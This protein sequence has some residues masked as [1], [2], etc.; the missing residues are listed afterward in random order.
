MDW[1]TLLR[2]AGRL[3]HIMVTCSMRTAEFIPENAHPENGYCNGYKTLRNSRKVIHLSS[4]C[5]E[6]TY[7]RKRR[8]SFI[9]FEGL[10]LGGA[11]L[12][13]CNQEQIM[14]G[15]SC[16]VLPWASRRTQ[17]LKRGNC[18]HAGLKACCTKS[19]SDKLD[20]TREKRSPTRTP[21]LLLHILIEP[22]HVA[23]QPIM[24]IARSCE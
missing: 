15:F 16:E 13:R 8:H 19:D 12:Q 2:T 23:S 18:C 21:T 20:G 11:G 22:F 9:I 5:Q 6:G 10:L 1:K 4:R 24:S 3:A 7:L 17:W 14:I